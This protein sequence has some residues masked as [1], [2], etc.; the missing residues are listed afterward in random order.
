[1]KTAILSKAHQ[2]PQLTD[3]ERPK[4]KEHDVLVRVDA[5]A[6]C[7]TDLHVI[8]GDLPSPKYPLVLGHEIVGTIEEAGKNVDQLHVGDRVGI[9]W[10]ASACLQCDYCKNGKE[11]L[12]DEAKFTGYTVDGGFTEYTIADSRFC[13]RIPDNYDSV[14]AA[15]LLC[16]GL[17]GWRSLRFTG[18]A[19]KLGIYGFGAA[20]HVITPVAL[21]EGKK[22]FAFTSPGDTERQEFA[23]ELGCTWAG[24]SDQNAPEELDGAIIFA[25]VGALV[26][27]A[28]KAIRKGG[29][30]V[31][32]GIHMS[33]IP[34]FSYDL[35]WGERTVRSVANLTR[36]DGH[37]F[38]KRI[39][40]VQI[41]THVRRFP[42]SAL[43]D[44][45]DQFR[46]GKI[47]GAAVIVPSQ[48]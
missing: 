46:H 10:L 26:P 17:I 21:S 22:V 39:S 35:L 9:P 47:K 43:N 27:T 41:Q 20:A 19:Y 36:A 12:C 4:V 40:D 34:S 48:S 30:V 8:D 23:R 13:F 7:R 16:A 11:N 32:G 29:T 31:C 28:L 1:M 5:C 2:Q 25:T 42:L 37:D 38:F 14:H 6:V 45:I 3:A 33:D 24:G 15:P 18:D 44:A